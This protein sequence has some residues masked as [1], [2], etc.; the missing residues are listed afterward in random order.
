MSASTVINGA[1]IHAQFASLTTERDRYDRETDEANTILAQNESQIAAQRSA[2]AV[3]SQQ[4]QTGSTTLGRSDREI[5]QIRTQL[6]QIRRQHATEAADMV[7]VTS[8]LNDLEGR[9]IE[10]ETNYF[11]ELDGLN[12]ELDAAMNRYDEGRIV[13]NLTVGSIADGLLPR[14]RTMIE[15]ERMK[16]MTTTA[17]DVNGH[18]GGNGGNEEE[19]AMMELEGTGTGGGGTTDDRA[20]KLQ[21]LSEQIAASLGHLRDATNRL[22]AAT[23]TREQTQK[24]I[25]KLR[26]TMMQGRNRDGRLF[27]ELDL[28]ELESKWTEEAN[29]HPQEDDLAMVGGDGGDGAGGSGG[30]GTLPNLSRGTAS[31]DLFYN[32]ASQEDDMPPMMEKGGGDHGVGIGVSGGMAALE[33]A[34]TIVDGGAG[35]AAMMQQ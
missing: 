8:Q 33:A 23:R 6:D 7:Q 22:G 17:D 24:E 11:G 35:S 1:A 30:G 16:T 2:Q 3:L 14:I 9:I 20:Q 18:G 19:N 28:S 32:A 10:S 21:D 12:D 29:M 31:L 27:S 15:S 25:G 26:S 4:I 34:K 5:Q 13:R